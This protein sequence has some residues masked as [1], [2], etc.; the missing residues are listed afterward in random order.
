MPK[1]ARAA[2][3]VAQEADPPAA[4]ASTMTA[5]LHGT[6]IAALVQRAQR[7]DV[8]AFGRLAATYEQRIYGFARSF[9][10]DPHEARDLA[11]EALLKVYRSLGGFR[12]QSSLLTWIFRVVRSVYLDH[13]KSRTAR[14]RRLEQP[15]DDTFEQSFRDDRERPDPEGELLRAEE[16]QALWTALEKVPEVFRSVLV[17]SDMQG[18]SY[19][20]VAVIVN[21]PVGTVKSRLFRGREALRAVLFATSDGKMEATPTSAANGKSRQ[22]S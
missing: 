14:E 16:R 13:H 15:L 18:L 22:E 9:T 4:S 7:G 8:K 11:Q 1:P 21:A 19:E 17:L 5:P 12:Y 2:T 6:E 3:P 10:S 20:E